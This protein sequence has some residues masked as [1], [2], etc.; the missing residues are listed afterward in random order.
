MIV[1]W[2]WKRKINCKCDKERQRLLGRKLAIEDTL[3]KLQTAYVQEADGTG[4]V[5]QR[6]IEN[7]TRL[8]QDAFN[9][10]RNQFAPE[11]LLLEQKYEKPG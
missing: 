10:A 2:P 11:V 1:C 7:I 6:G 8:K 5:G 4:G 9:Q 3:H